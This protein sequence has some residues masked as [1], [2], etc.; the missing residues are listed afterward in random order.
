MKQ[1]QRHI[2]HLFTVIRLWPRNV[3]SRRWQRSSAFDQAKT[4]AP[5]PL[6]EHAV[7]RSL[8]LFSAAVWSILVAKQPT[9][10]SF[11]GIVVPHIDL[12]TG[13][14]AALAA[15]PVLFS[16]TTSYTTRI[17]KRACEG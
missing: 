7:R 3:Y 12:P 16:I 4:S 8:S 5:S 1:V 9:T 17:A 13:K 14:C 6:L 15:S 2:L 10:S 11:S